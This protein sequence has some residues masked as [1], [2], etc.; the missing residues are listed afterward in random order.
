MTYIRQGNR[1]NRSFWSALAL[2]TFSACTPPS[3]DD[4]EVAISDEAAI[5]EVSEE[6]TAHT[7]QLDAL[8][9]RLGEP[10]LAGNCAADITTYRISRLEWERGAAAVR[11]F[12]G[13]DGEGYRSVFSAALGESIS[14]DGWLDER[15]WNRVETEFE[16]SDFWNIAS[17]EFAEDYQ[18]EGVMFVEGCKDGV[19]HHLQSEPRHHWLSRMVTMLSRIGKLQWLE[20]GRSDVG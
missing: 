15:T 3:T 10:P 20:T 11:V 14:S 7:S 1:T 12:S 18:R 4:S 8:L 19:Y 9:D 13:P 16:F 5:E 17:D 6:P 2:L